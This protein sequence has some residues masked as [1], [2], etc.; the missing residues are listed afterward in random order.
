MGLPAMV[1]AHQA[2]AER[3]VRKACREHGVRVGPDQTCSS[4][5]AAVRARCGS[6]QT[7][8]APDRVTR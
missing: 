8:R 3:H 2:L 5:A 1:Q 6:M 4:A 7:T